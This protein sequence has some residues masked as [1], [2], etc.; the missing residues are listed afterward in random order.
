MPFVFPNEGL[1]FQKRRPSFQKSA[2]AVRM[3]G[4]GAWTFVD[5]RGAF[6]VTE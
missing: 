5:L 6:S 3:K 2:A 4:C 1:P